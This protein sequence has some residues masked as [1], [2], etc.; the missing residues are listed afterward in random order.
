MDPIV[1]DHRPEEMAR[2]QA[3]RAA[4]FA[5][6]F[7]GFRTALGARVA[8]IALAGAEVEQEA[9]LAGLATGE[10]AVVLVAAAQAPLG[11]AGLRL[12]RA[13]GLGEIVLMAVDPGAQGRGVGAR[14]LAEALA[15]FRAAGLR[16]AVVGAG[17]DA[18][19]APARRLYRAAG[20][21]AAIPSVH[22]YRAL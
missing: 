7:A 20:F 19:H 6:I 9:L 5:P 2:L 15:R 14:L 13:A 1:R 4:A 10:D 16:A 21:D 18:A 17:G 12:D 3:I 22:L 8:E 11:F